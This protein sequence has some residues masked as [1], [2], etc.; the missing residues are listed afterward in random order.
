MLS[1]PFQT[2]MVFIPIDSPR[3]PQFDS[4]EQYI[5]NVRNLYINVTDQSTSR[6]V[7]IGVW[8]ILP[9][10]YSGTGSIQEIIRTS[11]RD[12]LI[13]LHGVYAN[14]A[15]PIKQYEVFRRHF[16]VLAVDHRGYGDSGQGADMTEIGIVEDHL[17]IYEWVRGLNPTADI[18]YWGH[19]LGTGLST[20]TLR[21]LK[22]DKNVVVKGL[23]LESPFTSL[24]DVINNIVFEQIFGWLAYFNSTLLR[25]LRKNGLEFRSLDH[26]GLIDSPVLI[27]HA[28]DDGVVPFKLG[29]QL[30]NIAI[31]NRN[32][33]QGSV[34]FYWFGE[35]LG[36]NHN[37]IV[38]YPQIHNIIENFTAIC[39]AYNTAKFLPI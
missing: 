28:K 19:S 30:A 15:K 24:E 13:Y 23:I 33:E 16:L 31:E 32:P 39:R 20:H 7:S 9:E 4:P 12:I 37:D 34:T 25:P 29:Q 5:S 38:T 27:L 1:L 8:L 17:Q 10:N 18:Y 21:R 22:D 3:N 6:E 26:I 11:S 36:Y 2:F 14:R 35:E